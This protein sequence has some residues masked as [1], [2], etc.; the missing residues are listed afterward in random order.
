MATSPLLAWPNQQADHIAI[1]GTV[2]IGD[3]AHL[4]QIIADAE[5]AAKF[6]AAGDGE[7]PSLDGLIKTIRTS[8]A[9]APVVMGDGTTWVLTR[10]VVWL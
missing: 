5:E 7:E 8:Q 6:K 9:V 4:D 3:K 2:P 10:Q 1:S